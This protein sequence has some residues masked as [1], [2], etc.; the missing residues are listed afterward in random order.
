MKEQSWSP[1]FVK[2]NKQT[3]KKNP[4]TTTTRKTLQ[5]TSSRL[6]SDKRRGGL[7]F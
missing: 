6:K 2:T 3:N 5:K 1:L 7:G 4:T